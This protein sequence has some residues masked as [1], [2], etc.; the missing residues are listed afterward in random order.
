[1]KHLWSPWRSAHINNTVRT[2]EQNPQHSVEGSGESIFTR[3]HKD[4]EDEKNLILWRGEL[5]FL[6]MNLYP[7]NNGHLLVVPYRQV[8]DYE[9]LTGPEMI[10]LAYATEL[11]IK[12]IKHALKPD[13]LNVGMNLGKAA[14]AGIPDHLHTHILPRWHGD[15]NFMPALANTKVIPESLAETYQKLKT[16]LAGLS[17]RPAPGKPGEQD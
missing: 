14:G 10:G 15:T 7:Y 6:I 16:S 5:V 4:H 8:A 13:A 9:D 12:C 3:L 1:M 17:V 2:D 11:G